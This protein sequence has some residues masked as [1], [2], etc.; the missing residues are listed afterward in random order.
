MA[1]NYAKLYQDAL[2]NAFPKVLYFGDLWNTPNKSVYKADEAHANTIYLPTVETSGRVNGSRSSIKAASVR[3][4]NDW[5]A[6][7]LTNHRIWDTLV[8]PHDINQTN[9]VLTLQNI[10]K[11][12]NEQQKFKEM[13]CYLASKI[14]TDWSALSG[15]AANTA[16]LTK[17]DVLAYIDGVME[18]MDDAEVP[19]SGRILYVTPAMNTLIKNAVEF[20]RYLS[21]TDKSVSRTINRIDELTVK[22]IPSDRMKTA[23]NFTEGAVPGASA[24]QIDMMFVHPLSV[25]PVTQY[26][27]ALLD[28]PSAVTNGM[29]YYFEEA[30]EDVFI[31]NKRADAIAFHTAA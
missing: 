5:E 6:K 13:D 29:Y 26:S 22:P 17:A 23:Y 20:Q 9:M 12:F 21:A 7:T 4:S 25:L 16:A 28:S 24:K 10:T 30:F 1:T 14:Y 8:H 19:G 3:H 11:A 2:A 18:A 31:L 27:Q 15:K